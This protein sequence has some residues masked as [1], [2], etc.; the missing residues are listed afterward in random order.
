LLFGFSAAFGDR[1]PS[2]STPSSTTDFRTNVRKLRPLSADDITRGGCSAAWCTSP[3]DGKNYG[4]DCWAGSPIEPCTCARGKARLTGKTHYDHVLGVNIVEYTCC[5][6]DLS[7]DGVVGENCG[8]YS[9]YQDWQ[10][11]CSTTACTS[12]GNDCLLPPSGEHCTCSG[13]LKPRATGKSMDLSMMGIGVVHDYMCCPESSD[14]IEAWDCRRGVL[15]ASMRIAPCM[16][17]A[18]LWMLFA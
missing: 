10:R 17:G 14:T 18:W 4:Y 9:G 2:N 12:E 13:G 6:E 5:T 7:A 3:L 16:V 8:E 1:D 15:S 11:E